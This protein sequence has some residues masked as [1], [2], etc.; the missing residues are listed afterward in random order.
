MSEL[1]QNIIGETSGQPEGQPMNAAA[2][3][4]EEVD[5]VVRY[6][7]EYRCTPDGLAAIK[8]RYRYIEDSGVDCDCGDS[9]H[10]N[11][12]HDLAYSDV[13]VLLRIIERQG[14]LDESST[15][16]VLGRAKTALENLST[17]EKR[18]GPLGINM[19]PIIEELVAAITFGAAKRSI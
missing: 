2:S 1:D 16:A 7:I 9:R 18:Y 14:D 5:E 12:L 4:K 10:E 17:W 6:S 13:P 3:N 11:A 8:R 15:D 19:R